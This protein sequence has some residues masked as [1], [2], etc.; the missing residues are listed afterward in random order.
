MLRTFLTPLRARFDVSPR[1]PPEN[2]S[3]RPEE[4]PTPEDFARDVLVELMRNS[5]EELKQAEDFENRIKVA[6]SYIDCY[7]NI[8]KCC[9][10]LEEIRRIMSQCQYTKDV[11]REMDGFICLYNVLSTIQASSGPNLEQGVDKSLEA[12]R[13][14]LEILSDATFEHEENARFLKV[15]IFFQH[16][17]A[18][19]QR[20]PQRAVGYEPLA[21]A[22]RALPSDA[23]TTTTVLG[24]LMSF[25]IHDFR[26][27]TL[28][29]ALYDV[30]FD[31]VDD[32]LA[33]HEPH[34]QSIHHPPVLSLLW[35]LHQRVWTRSSLRYGFARALAHLAG[36]SHRNLAV[37]SGA[38]LVIPIFN[39]FRTSKGDESVPEKERHAWQKLLRRLLEL[40]A[41]PAH[42]RAM[43][44]ETVQQGDT[45]DPETLDLIRYGMKSRWV[46]HFSME[47]PSGIVIT[48]TE[49]KSL[50]TSGITFMV[51]ISLIGDDR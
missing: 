42:A 30:E 29:K 2:V 49:R 39:H 9:E 25:V 11:F 35:S 34:L 37:M 33:K 21:L 40:G 6:T 43:L 31:V 47:G 19:V 28:F 26:M 46:D 8:L 45:L 36:A 13:L 18:T 10:I 32:L 12:V 48:D 50:P 17:L 1:F 27:V 41:D 44:Q 14:V 7:K 15:S 38:G 4:E 20:F 3:N 23:E 24:L 5:V 16:F 51:R 22:L